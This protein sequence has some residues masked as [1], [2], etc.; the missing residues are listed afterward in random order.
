M[1]S[2]RTRG[3]IHPLHH[4]SLRRAQGQMHF[5]NP[6]PICSPP[7]QIISSAEL[8]L[9]VL[10]RTSLLNTEL[11]CASHSEALVGRSC[12]H[13]TVCFR[14]NTALFLIPLSSSWRI[15]GKLLKWRLSPSLRCLSR[16]S[17]VLCYFD[18]EHSL[19]LRY[20]ASLQPFLSTKRM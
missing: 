18:T 11:L 17:E 2:L 12:C 8:K 6:R 4:M 13:K 7:H 14:Q 3:A 16:R 19:K 20:T 5:I 10:L 9:I 15:K 1:P